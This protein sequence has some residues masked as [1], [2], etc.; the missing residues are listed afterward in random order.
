MEDASLI[1]FL[2]HLFANLKK[3]MLRICFALTPTFQQPLFQIVNANMSLHVKYQRMQKV[4]EN[5][6]VAPYLSDVLL[7]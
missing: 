1:L 7:P 4:L 2:V 3:K 6:W 5:S